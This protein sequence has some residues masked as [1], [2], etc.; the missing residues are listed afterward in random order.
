M[1][2]NNDEI[3]IYDNKNM[4]IEKNNVVY[5]TYYFD[6]VTSQGI[7]YKYNSKKNLHWNYRATSIRW[8]IISSRK[9]GYFF[10]IIGNIFKL[11]YDIIQINLQVKRKEGHLGYP[12]DDSEC[13]WLYRR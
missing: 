1:L 9:I 12:Q 4:V 2:F 11:F 6:K 13:T 3:I 7:Y 10:D 8:V 5:N